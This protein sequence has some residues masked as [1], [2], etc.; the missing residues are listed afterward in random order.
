M[1]RRPRRLEGMSGA[2]L[3]VVG[4]LCLS[5]I[6]VVGTACAFA[7]AHPGTDLPPAV[8][9]L[10]Q[11]LVVAVPA[12]LA[13]TYADRS[14]TAPQP[15]DPSTVTAAPGSTVTLTPPAPDP[16]PSPEQLPPDPS[17]A[18]PDP[19]GGDPVDTG[20]PPAADAGLET[21]ATIDPPA[22]LALAGTDGIAM[23]VPA[24]KSA[25]ARRA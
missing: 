7:F 23:R 20:A 25:R 18:L 13:K 11:G 24:K 19:T 6:V 22:V 5:L 4:A 21:E 16:T 9:R 15:G 3:L 8:D 1:S 2:G 17:A 12:L 14:G 10:L